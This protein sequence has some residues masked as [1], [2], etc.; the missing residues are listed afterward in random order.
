MEDFHQ[1][2]YTRLSFAMIRKRI[3][4]SI[5]SYIIDFVCAVVVL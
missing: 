3:L 1:E 5:D 2:P 4:I